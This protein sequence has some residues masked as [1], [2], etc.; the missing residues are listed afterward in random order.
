M[1]Y[2]PYLDGLRAV[3]V[4]SV[5]LY[6]AGIGFHGGYVGVDV[7]FV[8]SGYLITG[9][10]LKDLDAGGFRIGDFWERRIRRIFPA[11]AVVIAFSLVAGWFVLLPIHF[12]ELGQSSIFQALILSNAYFSRTTGYFEQTAD[13]KPL[14][15]TWSLAVE[16]QF[17]L[18]FP[19]LLAKV[20]SG[21]RRQV[22]PFIAA[23]GGA[24]FV[25]SVIGSYCFRSQTF[26]YLPMR[27]WELLIGAMLA[28]GIP[29]PL[30]LRW[31]AE[32][33]SLLGI[34][35]IA[36]SVFLY[37]GTTRFPGAT[38]LLPCA[39]AAMIIWA[40][41]STTTLVGRL[42]AWPPMVFVGLISYSLYL[43]H[44]PLL[45]YF[46]YL[47]IDPFS[48]RQQMVWLV[49]TLIVATL[50]WR[51]VETPFRKRVVFAERKFLFPAAAMVTGLFLAFGLATVLLDGVP[52]RLSPKLMGYG[53][54]AD[55]KRPREIQ[56]AD[57]V[58]GNFV[59]LGKG[60]KSQ[61]I[62]FLV[63]GDS[64]AMAV[65]PILETLCKEHSIR[66]VGAVR[67][68]MTPLVDYVSVRP[69]GYRDYA[70]FNQ[71]V[72]ETVRQKRVSDVLLVAVWDSELDGTDRL[73]RGLA[74][75]IAAM[76]GSVDRIWIM[77]PVPYP[78]RN[79]PVVLTAVALRGG[80]TESIGLPVSEHALLTRQ[81]DPSFGGLAGP[82]V[83][84][85]D[86]TPFFLDERGSICCFE[87]DGKALYVDGG[88]ISEYGAMLLRP[89][90]EP[91]FEG[92]DKAAKDQAPGDPSQANA[93]NQ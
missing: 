64:H 7:F 83:T 84:V 25:A 29:K 47:S 89:M 48:W 77:R 43:W 76:K 78:R 40:N 88:H 59:E 57:A 21:S 18:L 10:I 49:L 91:I 63:W 51:F 26:Y 16:E 73:H 53:K 37:D 15:H 85:L 46:R 5:I 69:D 11:L 3:A 80:D 87:K 6:H 33:V 56:L 92:I 58:K 79:V 50:S 45:V 24:S 74:S 70:A 62:R 32:L 93:P 36:S 61:P 60:D 72:L 22:V 13:M 68:A 1:K 75:T 52:S 55:K 38:A 39:G 42:L 54:A 2:R 30:S 44:W 19:F 90:F 9:L 17:Y 66:G 67:S 34:C 20:F 71:A 12:R 82:G 23:L 86:P 31:R 4:L 27:A 41:L 65:L 35:A 81:L 28:A 14:L 8:I